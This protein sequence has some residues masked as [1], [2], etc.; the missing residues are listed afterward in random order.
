MEAF[1]AIGVNRLS[2]GV[3][4][5]SPERR[6]AF[7][8]DATIAQIEETAKWANRIFDYVNIDIIFGQPGQDLSQ[9]LSDAQKAIDLDTTT[10]DFYTLNN[11]AAQPRMHDLFRE[12]GYTV[13][14][15][16]ERINQRRE[17]AYFMLSKGYNRINGYSYARRNS[18]ETALIQNEP[19]FLYHDIL[20]GFSSD[21]IIGYGASAHSQ[22]PEFGIYNTAERNLYIR[23][24]TER[25]ILP[26]A[27]GK[28]VENTEKGIVTFPYR[29]FIGHTEFR[30]EKP[31]ERTLRIMKQF[32][33]AKLI[34]KTKNGFVVTESG[35][36]YYVNMMYHLM[37]T[38]ARKWISDT[39]RKKA[40][41]RRPMEDSTL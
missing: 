27:I 2:F 24:I 18:G 14:N 10:I 28:I 12:I 5:F 33:M 1:R 8:L 6:R 3:Q 9:I 39:I 41:S 37:P 25:N 7:N 22:L 16:R 4:T 38:E 19:Q 26:F 36:L 20:Y 17:I 31:S 34:E 32:E 11:L 21:A 23:Y 35:W 29:G 30:K 13:P 40:G 15:A